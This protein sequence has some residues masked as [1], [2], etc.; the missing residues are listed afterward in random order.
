MLVE[1]G[2]GVVCMFSFFWNLLTLMCLN[3]VEV[4]YV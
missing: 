4:T 1:F 3:E 2:D